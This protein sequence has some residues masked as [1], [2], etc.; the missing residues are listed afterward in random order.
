MALEKY[1]L[2]VTILALAVVTLVLFSWNAEGQSQNKQEPPSIYCKLA[3]DKE[4]CQILVEGANTAV[5]ATVRAIKIS[6]VIAKKMEPMVDKF[7]KSLDMPPD[8]KNTVINTC[9]KDYQKVIDNLSAAL[10]DVNKGDTAGGNAKLLT[11]TMTDCVA[12]LDQCNVAAPLVKKAKHE[13]DT[14]S[15]TC[16]LVAKSG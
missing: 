12:S 9:N 2:N 15:Q 3:E 16:A 11:P 4:L 13:L 8:S 1:N 7:I 6:I 10:N 14:Y 5:E